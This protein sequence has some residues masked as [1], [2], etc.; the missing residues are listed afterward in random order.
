MA[1]LRE[2]VYL[3]YAPG[4]GTTTARLSEARRRTGRG[5]DVVVRACRVHGDLRESRSGLEIVGG[6][7]GLRP[8][9]ADLFR[10]A[11]GWRSHATA[12]YARSQDVISGPA[13][14]R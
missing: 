1:L 6:L 2:R 8:S 12:R 7:R 11:R 4:S 10:S 13:R 9:P 5:T 14:R 3:G